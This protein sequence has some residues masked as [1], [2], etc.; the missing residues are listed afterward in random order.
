[1]NICDTLKIK[2]NNY[3]ELSEKIHCDNSSSTYCQ[4]LLH[5][6]PHLGLCKK[7]IS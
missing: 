7:I 6:R 5:N 1:M 2:S 4:L 3:Y